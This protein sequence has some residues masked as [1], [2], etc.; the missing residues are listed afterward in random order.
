MVSV[1]KLEEKQ[2]CILKI[3][4][5]VIFKV[6][7]SGIFSKELYQHNSYFAAQDVQYSQSK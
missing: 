6:A 2:T 4:Q 5:H 3:I 1:I 7:L